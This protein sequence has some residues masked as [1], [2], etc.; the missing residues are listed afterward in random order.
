[1]RRLCDLTCFIHQLKLPVLNTPGK[2]WQGSRTSTN[3]SLYSR[4]KIYVCLM[5]LMVCDRRR[6]D[7][8]AWR[9]ANERERERVPLDATCSSYVPFESLAPAWPGYMY[10]PLT[11]TPIIV[12]LIIYNWRP[13]LIGFD[14]RSI[15]SSH[16]PCAHVGL[17]SRALGGSRSSDWWC[18]KRSCAAP[19]VE[20]DMPGT[21]STHIALFHLHSI[22]SFPSIL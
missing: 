20:R 19:V 11:Y 17:W 1:M 10:V 8:T 3:N 2:G 13:R 21:Q 6:L 16:V 12:P 4:G 7:W 18:W 15:A 9:R 5:Y 22:S 14:R